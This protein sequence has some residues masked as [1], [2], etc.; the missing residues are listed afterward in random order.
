M[1]LH[2]VR[3]VLIEEGRMRRCDPAM[4]KKNPIILALDIRDP[5]QLL[6]ILERLRPL[7]CTLKV[8]DLVFEEGFK[9]LLPELQVYGRVMVDIK[10]HDIP[11]TLNNI[12][13]RLSKYEP[14]A[15]TVHAS[16]GTKMVEQIAGITSQIETKLLAIT[17]LTSLKDECRDIYGKEASAKVMDLARIAMDAG[18]NGLVCSAHEVKALREVYPEALLVTPGLRSPGADAGDQERVAT[19]AVAK[20]N[21]ADGLVMGR[22]IMNS[23]DPVAEVKRVLT[24]ELGIVL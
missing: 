20:K 6:P 18:A 14:W 16:G 2:D 4:E 15:V 13:M 7:G 5:Q 9:H 10:G 1:T 24:K 11:N 21:G 23:M 22:Q 12:S 3:R 8:N 17:V 19:P